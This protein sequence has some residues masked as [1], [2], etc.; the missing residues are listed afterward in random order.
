MFSTK[1]QKSNKIHTEDVDDPKIR[2]IR[3]DIR[4]MKRLTE[5]Q[6][7][8]IHDLSH[9][10]KMYIIRLYDSMMDW[11]EHFAENI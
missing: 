9:N 6:M 4:N 3:H 10:D 11:F 1:S 7:S 5:S 8:T 2:Q